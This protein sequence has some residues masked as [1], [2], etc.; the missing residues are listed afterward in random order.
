MFGEWFFDSQQFQQLAFI[1]LAMPQG[2][3]DLSSPNRDQTHTPTVEVQS[4]PPG[5]SLSNCFLIQE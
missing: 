2:M 3:W 1:L 5:K 4:L